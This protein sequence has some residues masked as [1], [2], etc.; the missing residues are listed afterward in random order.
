MS[1]IVDY[2]QAVRGELSH[3]SWPSRNQA[4]AYTV[5][6]IGI[7]LFISFILGA[8]DF[9]FTYLLEQLIILTR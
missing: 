3:V 1:K 9:V 5:L 6:V 7:S 8:F 2:V 4:I